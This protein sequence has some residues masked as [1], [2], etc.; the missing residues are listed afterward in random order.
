MK[1]NFEEMLNMFKKNVLKNIMLRFLNIQADAPE[2][3]QHN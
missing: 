1:G 3:F 2:S